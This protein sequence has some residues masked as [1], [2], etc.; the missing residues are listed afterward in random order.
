LK[1]GNIPAVSIYGTN[2]GLATGEKL[3]ESK[4]LLLPD[5]K[6]VAIEG[7]NHAQ[8]GSYGFQAGDNEADITPEA[9]WTQTA[10]ATVD[11]FIEV[12][13]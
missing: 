7:G 3:D 4:A 6:F 5:T 13:K 12:L 8:F 9:Q 11:F 2:D 1:T 10:N